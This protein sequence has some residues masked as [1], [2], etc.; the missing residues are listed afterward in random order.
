LFG[1]GTL[2]RRDPTAELL[3]DSVP[4]TVR[5]IDD[6]VELSLY[7]PMPFQA[8][9][10]VSLAG[11]GVAVPNLRVEVRTVPYAD[12]ANWVGYFHASYV[13]HGS[14]TPGVDLS[15]LD[16]TQIEGGGDWCGHL[17]G[18]SF[19]F[20]D[21]AAL[22]TLEG[23]PRFFFDDSG[24]PQVHGTGTEEWGGGGDYWGGRT[25][26]LPLAGHPTGAPDLASALAPADQIESAY[27]FLLADLMPFGRN[28]RVQLEHGGAD[29]STEHYRTVAFWYGLPSACLVPTDHL[30]VGDS[31]AEALHQYLSPTASAPERLTSRFDG[32]GV[33]HVGTVPVIP[34]VTERGRH[35]TGT[36]QMRLAIRPDNVG[37][38]LRRR[39]DYAYPDQ[40]AEVEVADDRDDAPFVRAGTWYLAGSTS[41][42][43]SNPPG[44]T[45]AAVHTVETSTRRLRDDEFLIASALTRGKSALRVRITFQPL[46]RPLYP[47]A[48]PAAQAWSELQYWAYS[49][50]MP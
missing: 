48:P 9:A 33:D 26:T 37:V 25:M 45:D 10:R 7:F 27:R 41:C 22:G 8:R 6:E 29:D 24:S 36:T 32:L 46:A 16:T 15:L 13:D 38:L 49:Y 39:L 14:P 42:V 18:T 1:A 35:M 44:E 47:G 28:A 34:E 4:A 20:S 31:V 11:G 40:R 43:Y 23:D 5:F 50:V 12:P 21:R 3:V 2:Y 30:Q 19:V 17:V